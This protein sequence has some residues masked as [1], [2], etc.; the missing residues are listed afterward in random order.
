MSIDGERP[1]TGKDGQSAPLTWAEF[2]QLLETMTAELRSESAAESDGTVDEALDLPT[3]DAPPADGDPEHEPTKVGA[4]RAAGRGIAAEPREEALPA[5]LTAQYGRNWSERGVEE[6]LASAVGGRRPAPE[7]AARTRALAAGAT[8]LVA[9]A[10]ASA[11]MAYLTP[12]T[13]DD[14]APTAQVKRAGYVAGASLLEEQALGVKVAP[15]PL[16]PRTVKVTLVRADRDDA[17]LHEDVTLVHS[18]APSPGVA[19]ALR[20]HRPTAA[21]SGDAQHPE[22]APATA[23]PGPDAALRLPDGAGSA[24][25]TIDASGGPTAVADARQSA[26]GVRQAATARATVDTPEPTTLASLEGSASAEPPPGHQDAA[27]APAEDLGANRTGEEDVEAMLTRADGLMQSGDVASARRLLERAA[28]TGDAHVAATAYG[29]AA[30]S[31]L[32]ALML[33]LDGAAAASDAP[34]QPDEVVAAPGAYAGVPAAGG[35]EASSQGWLDFCSA[36]FR[37]FDPETGMYRGYSG[38]KQYCR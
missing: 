17:G 13:E 12:Q 19:D 26:G 35:H 1:E 32:P 30:V 6:F 15:A 36:K 34:G 7:C 33:V 37:S 28:D 5:F 27:G 21:R 18:D 10:A 24:R 14:A 8:L 23:A 20:L 4:E 31:R 29:P 9:V 16:T 3:A 2:D 25:A 38:K 11:S 22:A